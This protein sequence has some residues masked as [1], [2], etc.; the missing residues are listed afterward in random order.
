[1]II[2]LAM[3]GPGEEA[4]STFKRIQEDAIVIPDIDKMSR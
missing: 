2:G 4:P 1:M 3:H